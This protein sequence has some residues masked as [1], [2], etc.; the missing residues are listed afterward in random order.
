[1]I[2]IIV[3]GH[4][5][6]ASGIMSSLELIAGKQEKVIG[7][8]F[9]IEDNTESLESKLRAAANELIDCEG[10][11]FLTDIVGGTPFKTCAL[12][13]Q[14]IENSKVIAGTNLGMLLEVS[15]SRESATVEE[16]KNMSLESGKN[17]IKA[18][19]T[20]AKKQVSSN[21]I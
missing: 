20:K 4:G 6:F 1:M 9:T 21:G 5:N 14:N 8:D 13:T 11:L 15:L 7:I 18:Y 17:A 3:S 10:I 12:L 16:L 19:E 2:G